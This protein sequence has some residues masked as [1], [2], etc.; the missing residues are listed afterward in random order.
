MKLYDAVLEID[1]GITYYMGDDEDG[2]FQVVFSENSDDEELL[3]RVYQVS[4]SSGLP[5]ELGD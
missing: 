3:H 5:M 2:N 4:M 1:D